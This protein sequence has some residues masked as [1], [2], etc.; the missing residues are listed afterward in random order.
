MKKRLMSLFLT[1]AVALSLC[2]PAFAV[3]SSSFT[4]VGTSN[5]YDTQNVESEISDS[6]DVSY[7]KQLEA[8]GKTVVDEHPYVPY[9]E[10][11]EL[12][13]QKDATVVE[14]TD[15]TEEIIYGIPVCEES[16]T[17]ARSAVS[18]FNV[19]LEGNGKG[20]LTAKLWR[21][22]SAKSYNL[23]MQ[24]LYG[25]CRTQT[26]DKVHDTK[27][28]ITSVGTALSPTTITTNISTTKYFVV[29]LTGKIGDGTVNYTTYNKLFNKRA[30]PYPEYTCPVSGIYCVPPYYSN[31]AAGTSVAWNGRNAYIKWFN[32][33]YNGGKDPWD[34]SGYQIHHI[35]P[36]KY[37][38]TNEYS[39][40]IPLTKKYAY[41]FQQLVAQLLMR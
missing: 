4:D 25:T 14:Y 9:D 3:E 22:G 5:V 36:R 28:G 1:I 35:R 21:V 2:V 29:K 8:T 38:G 37:G 30:V 12:E 27:S 6:L 7:A 17:G 32:N 26:A 34:W 18:Y 16:S 11:L 41:C 33:T 15:G 10:Q 31:F 24:I 20:Q 19:S 23:T 40:L 39:N 13:G